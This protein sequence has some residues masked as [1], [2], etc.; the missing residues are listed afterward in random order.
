LDYNALRESVVP[1]GLLF[2]LKPAYYQHVT[3]AAFRCSP[4][5]PAK[6]GWVV[7]FLSDLKV[8]NKFN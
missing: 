3:L 7:E 1:T 6:I 2:I 4:G 8:E 5:A